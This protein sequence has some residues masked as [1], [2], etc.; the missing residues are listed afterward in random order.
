MSI[1]SPLKWLQSSRR[2]QRFAVFV[3]IGILCNPVVGLYAQ[4]TDDVVVIT[5]EATATYNTPNGD[6]GILSNQITTGLDDALIDP[7][8]DILGCDGQ[9]LDSY[10][11]F[12]MS[13]YE[14]DATGLD[15]GVIVPL[16][17][18]TG[19]DSIAPNTGNINPF[20]LLA[21]EGRYNFLLDANTDLVSPVN[22]GLKQTDAGAQYIL[23]INPPDSSDF[24]ERRVLIEMLGI[25]EDAVNNTSVLSYRAISLDGQSISIDGATELVQTVQVNNAETQSLT[26]FEFGFNT[27]I[28]EAEQVRI[29]KSAD[30]SAA[31]PGDLVVYRLNIQNLAGVEVGSIIALDTFPVGFELVPD[32]VSGQV[33]DTTVAINTTVSGSTVGFSLAETLGAEDSLDI[34][35]AARLTADALRGTGRN[36]AIVTAER[37]DS[38]VRVQNGPSTH[39]ITLDPGILS[40]C[41]TLI[42]R[43]FEDKNF[44]GEQQSGEAGIPNAVIFLDD[45][46]RV[47][48]DGDGLF[49]VQKMLP[50]R[51]T[52]TLDISSLPGY[53]LAPNLYFNERNSR[54]RLVNLAPGGLVRMNFGVTPTFQEGQ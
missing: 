27:T 2:W 26:F 25:V 47:V 13:L 12:V 35:Y 15:L 37:T 29:T 5:N 30:R 53:T 34:I 16:T 10:A 32:S 46:N 38:G 44:D 17:P 39:R 6:I 9:P 43:V 3:L 54:S 36:S 22:T 1:F 4:T 51:R 33:N 41:G 18:T 19:D 28:C 14:P 45:G 11:G 8:G 23:V 31:Q 7:A 42:G 24:G 52:G 49:S 21:D 20:P 40:D 50:G 48:T